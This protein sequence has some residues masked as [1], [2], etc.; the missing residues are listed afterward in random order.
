MV[1]K[2]KKFSII[3]T[4]Y[5]VIITLLEDLLGTI[6][7]SK[8]LYD[9]FIKSKCPETAG[10][11]EDG[12]KYVEDLEEAGWTGFYSDEKGLFVF[13]YYIKGFVKNAGNILKKQFEITALKSKITDFLFIHPR[14]IYLGFTEPT[15]VLERPIRVMTMQGPR[16]ALIRSDIVPAGTEISFQIQLLKHPDLKIEVVRELFNYGLLQ[17]LGQWRNGGYGRFEVKDFTEK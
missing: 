2:T 17:G 14:K 6:P 4:E 5:D 8:E 3:S 1:A 10:A 15:G 12:D 13:D 7:K 11:E 16:V 9:R